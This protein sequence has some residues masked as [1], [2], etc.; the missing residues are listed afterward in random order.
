MS[1]SDEVSSNLTLLALDW[2]RHTLAGLQRSAIVAAGGSNVGILDANGV[3][4]STVISMPSSRLT[5]ESN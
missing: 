2:R 5:I 3:N 4:N 1:F